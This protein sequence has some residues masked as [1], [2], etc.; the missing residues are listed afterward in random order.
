[1][2]PSRAQVADTADFHRLGSP[3]PGLAANGVRNGPTRLDDLRERQELELWDRSMDEWISQDL[4]LALGSL[5][6]DW[7][8]RWQ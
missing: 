5:A 3:Y 4:E 1:M 8:M 7:R 6:E 2:L